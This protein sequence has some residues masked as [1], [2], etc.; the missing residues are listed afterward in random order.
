MPAA[1]LRIQLRRLVLKFHLPVKNV[2]QLAAKREK[3][4]EKGD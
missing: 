3:T 1:M 2:E 4:P